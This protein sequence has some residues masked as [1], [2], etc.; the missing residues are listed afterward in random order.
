M[1]TRRILTVLVTIALAVAD[2]QARDVYLFSYFVGQSDGLHL[3]YS[4]D[5][6]QW[7]ALNDGRS[8][9]T[10]TVGND[11]LMRDPSIVQ[12]PDGTF[13]MVWTSSW[14]DQIIGYASSR[15]LIHWSEQRAIP[16]MKHEPQAL[17]AWAPELFYDEPSHT[18]Y[19]YWATTIPGRH[20]PVASTEREKQWNHR[21]YYCTTQDFQTFSETK[22][23]FNPDFNVIDAAIVRQPKSG[24]LLMVVKNE[25]S[26]PAEKNLRVT[27]TKRIA[28][29]FPTK[30]S[31]PISP[32][33]IWCE[34][35]APLYVGDTLYVYF[36]MYRNHRYGVVRSLDDGKTWQDV[37][38]QLQIPSGIRHG[39]AFRVDD[40]VLKPLL[41]LH[42]YNP[43]IPDHIADGSVSKFGDTYYMYAT[44]DLDKGL[45]QCGAPVVWQSKDFVNW[46]FE[47]S[48]IQGFDWHQPFSYTD[49]KGKQRDGYW[50]Y[51][52][53]GRVVEKDGKY[54]LYVTLVSPDEAKMPTYVL[55]GDCP[56]GPFRFDSTAVVCPDI[57][58]EPFIDDNGKG[59]IFW[60][61]RHAARLSADWRSTDGETVSIPTRQGGYSEGPITFKRKG[62][63]YYLYTLSGR[64]NYHYAYMMSK[65]GP[66]AGYQAPAQGDIFLVSAPGNNVWGPGHGNVFY[67]ETS[68]RYAMLYLEYGDGGTTRQMY[69]NWLDFNDDGTIR[70]LVPD[71][72]GVGYLATPQEQRPNLALQAKFKASSERKDRQVKTVYRVR[73]YRAS[74]AGDGSNGT[75]WQAAD[76]DATPTLTMDLGRVQHVAETCF[77]PLH[78]TEGHR[79]HLAYSADGQSWTE[80]GR[81]SEPV[82]RSPHRVSIGQDLRFLRLTIDQGAPGIWEWKAYSK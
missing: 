8:M 27:T 59:Y 22:M 28:K 31:A 41:G 33:D 23:F 61:R 20:K 44:T 14:N 26:L 51:W 76:E 43:L 39:T 7:T 30:V 42:E 32:K 68:D 69:A 13:H 60:R 29:G 73:S 74:L 55:E 50:R 78:P 70:Q 15:D 54:L 81:Q 10:P 52:A 19:I 21:I 75:Y 66:L 5:G 53:P 71:R 79:W 25:N 80:C 17:N 65:E 35:P 3:A 58:G 46:S 56:T 36:D 38:D 77:Y 2:M 1:F 47:G 11:R 82:A 48:H 40:A 24:R 67:D 12:G 37:S 49:K 72:Y 64:E 9:L 4:Y 62:I 57:D 6:L 45:E 34:G 18:Y 16:V 63:Y